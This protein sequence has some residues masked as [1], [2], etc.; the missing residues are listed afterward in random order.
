VFLCIL[1]LLHWGFR[2]LIQTRLF[3]IKGKFIGKNPPEWDSSLDPRT[4]VR[5][6]TMGKVRGS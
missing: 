6:V 1:K 3:Y 5:E 4:K 2:E